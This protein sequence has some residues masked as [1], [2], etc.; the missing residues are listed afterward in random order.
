MINLFVFDERG[1]KFLF[2]DYKELKFSKLYFSF[3]NNVVIHRNV[4]HFLDENINNLK[5]SRKMYN[6]LFKSF[7]TF[8]FK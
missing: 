6:S 4:A 3:V 1:N 7:L 2:I 5:I 8:Y